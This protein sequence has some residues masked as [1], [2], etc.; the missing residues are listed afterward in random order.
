MISTPSS[1]PAASAPSWTFCQKTCETPLGMTAMTFLPEPCRLQ[2]GANRQAR[3]ASRMSAL[4]LI[5]ISPLRLLVEVVRLQAPFP[6]QL[7][8]ALNCGADADGERRRRDLTERGTYG[9]VVQLDG[10][11]QGLLRAGDP[12]L[13]ARN[14]AVDRGDDVGDRH[15]VAVQVEDV[16][17]AQVRGR[18]A[19]E[20][21]GRIGDI[22]KVRAAAEAYVV[23]AADDHR[24]HGFGRVGGDAK[25]AANAV[26][27]QRP[28]A[29]AADAVVEIVDA[30]VVLVAAL[31]SSIESRRVR[32]LGFGQRPVV[33]GRP[34][35]GG[36]TGVNDLVDLPR[37]PPR[38]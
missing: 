28:Q 3:A 17:A 18:G 24:L 37:R 21:I 35:D 31:K 6:V 11:A 26:D 9:R 19:D 29:D 38:R 23:V 14:D 10:D 13:R 12:P 2:A 15:R 20:D 33:L 16:G 4:R 27:R 34:E 8:K 25:I 32:R 30:R 22:L 5:F 7:G 1:L 36:G